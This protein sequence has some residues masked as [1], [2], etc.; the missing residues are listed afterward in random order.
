MSMLYRDSL[1]SL[2]V[3]VFEES[4]VAAVVH[5]RSR[6]LRC[7]CLMNLKR[8][9]SRWLP[10]AVELAPVLWHLEHSETRK[11]TAYKVPARPTRLKIG[12]FGMAL[13]T[14]R[15]CLRGTPSSTMT[16]CRC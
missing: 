9:I 1:R 12:G 5:P 7:N 11:E 16:L 10:A 3:E 8:K 14:I 15:I 4:L 6:H 13:Q 2:Q